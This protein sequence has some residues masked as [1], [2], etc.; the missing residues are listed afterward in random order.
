[1]AGGLGDVSVGFLKSMFDSLEAIRGF[2]IRDP[3]PASIPTSMEQYEANLIG[4]YE[5]Q[6]SESLGAQSSIHGGTTFQNIGAEQRFSQS[7]N[8]FFAAPEWGTS[9]VRLTSGGE[10]IQPSLLRLYYRRHLTG[11]GNCPEGSP[12]KLRF[13]LADRYTELLNKL[14]KELED[15][16]LDLA[17]DDVLE[18]VKGEKYTPEKQAAEREIA[19]MKGAIMLIEAIVPIIKNP[20]TDSSQLL[21]HE[22]LINILQD[23]ARR[24]LGLKL[25]NMVEVTPE[26]KLSLVPRFEELV[27]AAGGYGS[28]FFHTLLEVLMKQGGEDLFF[29]FFHSFLSEEGSEPDPLI[30]R[31]ASATADHDITDVTGQY[32][33][34]A[35]EQI[36][37]PE[38]REIAEQM[39]GLFEEPLKPSLK[40]DPALFQL[41]S[42]I[43]KK[44][45]GAFLFFRFNAHFPDTADGNIDPLVVRLLTVAATHDIEVV[46]RIFVLKALNMV[47]DQDKR[48]LAVQLIELLEDQDELKEMRKSASFEEYMRDYKARR[49]SGGGGTNGVG[50]SS[51][52]P[53]ATPSSSDEEISAAPVESYDDYDPSWDSTDEIGWQEDFYYGIDAMPPPEMYW[54]AGAQAFGI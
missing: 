11:G 32:I 2:L 50:G 17:W 4:E 33:G 44:P 49:G 18:D 36:S 6:C 42:D 43:L 52:P 40:N 48:S 47:S 31:L 23:P 38:N 34:R 16:E 45:N 1:M 21:I 5:Q 9:W 14:K 20:E 29:K 13:A 51:A 27:A 35:L 25:L 30:E 26:K 37:N 15:K 8:G 12:A 3:M 39:V 7:M 54:E 53:A 46:P 28:P 19:L 22:I 10:L 24:S 41:M